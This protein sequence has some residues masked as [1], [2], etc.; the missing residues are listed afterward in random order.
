MRHLILP[1]S[2]LLAL[3]ALWAFFDGLVYRVVYGELVWAFLG[4]L[5]VDW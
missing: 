2:A 4:W 5:G 1:L 3:W